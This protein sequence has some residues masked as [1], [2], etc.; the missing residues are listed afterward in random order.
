MQAAGQGAWGL[1]A[2]RPGF[3]AGPLGALWPGTSDVPSPGLS[4]LVCREEASI[5]LWRSC[6]ACVARRR[7]WGTVGV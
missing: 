1:Q 3:E 2:G 5:L 7:P 4:L 6:E